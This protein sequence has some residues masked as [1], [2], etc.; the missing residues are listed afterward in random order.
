MIGGY[1][2]VGEGDGNSGYQEASYVNGNRLKYDDQRFGFLGDVNLD[3]SISD[4]YGST[5]TEFGGPHLQDSDRVGWSA[6]GDGNVSYYLRTD[7]TTGKAYIAPVWGSSSDADHL[8]MPLLAAAAIATLGA[9]APFAAA[10]AA[11]SAGAAGAVSAATAAELSA[12]N[13]GMMGAGGTAAAAGGAAAG[14]AG[15]LEAMGGIAPVAVPGEVAAGGLLSAAPTAGE[16][17]VLT[18]A[19]GESAGAGLVGVDGVL[20]AAPGGGLFGGTVGAGGATGPG[21]WEWI[22]DNPRLVGGLLGGV[23]GAVGGGDEGSGPAP[24]TGPMPTITRGDWKPTNTAQ[25]MQSPN[26][27]LLQPQGTR[28]PNSGLG[29]YMGLLGG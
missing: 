29:R 28:Q 2:T 23:N 13:A 8:R 21:L 27:G 1:N 5:K 17:G 25:M 14:G 26:Y 3:G 20:T 4:A 6:Q 11:G 15:L 12:L 9:T 19:A 18:G 22:K 7:P 24:Y 16:Y 10:G